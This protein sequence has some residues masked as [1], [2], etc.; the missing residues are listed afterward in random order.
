MRMYS[1]L[2]P[3]AKL[4]LLGCPGCG[5]STLSQ[6]ITLDWAKND[7]KIPTVRLVFPVSLRACLNDSTFNLSDILE[8]YFVRDSATFSKFLKCST[9][10]DGEGVCFLL[11]G[12]EDYSM[13]KRE[14]FLSN[15]LKGET[16][17]KSVIIVTSKPSS[18]VRLQSL[19][20]RQVEILGL[21]STHIH[22]YIHSYPFSNRSKA[23]KLSTFLE[24]HPNVMSMC[25]LP[26]RLEIIAYL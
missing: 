13:L 16:L 5:K 20:T 8:R 3:G 7:L 14:A 10:R 23:S 2:E 4:L 19:A 15:L 22:E 24:N 21:S 18:A 11:D 26:Y 25:Y 12:L 17:G 1:D 9:D 6:R